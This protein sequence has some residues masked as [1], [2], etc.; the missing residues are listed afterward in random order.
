MKPRAMIGYLVGFKASNIWRIWVPKAHK[1]LNARD[2]VFD[3]NS[4]YQPNSAY[5][6]ID[7]QS[8]EAIQPLSTH[9]FNLVIS[10]TSIKE[11]LDDPLTI[12]PLPDEPELSSDNDIEEL[13]SNDDIEKPKNREHDYEDQILG[14]LPPSPDES[15]EREEE[16]VRQNQCESEDNLTLNGTENAPYSGNFRVNDPSLYPHPEVGNASL[17]SE[18]SLLS[19]IT[20]PAED[21]TPDARVPDQSPDFMVLIDNSSYDEEMLN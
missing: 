20:I 11:P 18:P 14:D 13:L 5:D 6:V 19:Q 4:F 2:C 8:K 7:D 16:E 21:L 17:P 12:R 9:E 3:E 15:E 1:V 10:E